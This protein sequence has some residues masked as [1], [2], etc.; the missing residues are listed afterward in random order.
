[1]MELETVFSF[2]PHRSYSL[3]HAKIFFPNKTVLHPLFLPFGHQ[4]L[5]GNAAWTRRVVNGSSFF[6]TSAG[7]QSS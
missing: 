5:T 6:S 3:V 7:F 1:M 4:Q 2:L